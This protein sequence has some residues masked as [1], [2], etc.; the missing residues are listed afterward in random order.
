MS[1]DVSLHPLTDEEYADFVER[2]VDEYA[3]QNVNAGEWSPDDA[4]ARA[5]DALVDLR[6]D[7]LRGT[8]HVF[9]KGVAE[10][11]MRLGWL[12]IAPAPDF[13]GPGRER[14]R[15]LSQ[16]TVEERLRGQGV[17][18]ALL[19][20][21]H[22]RLSAERVDELWLRVFDW[23]T[24]AR[25][26]YGALGYELVRHFATDVPPAQAPWRPGSDPL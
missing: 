6:A 5:R 11:G 21:L 20:A 23:N 22:D 4:L 8:G 18:W 15:W 25:R 9:L 7:R 19:A 17:G 24:A 1:L 14:T 12:W 16:I 2:Q 3:R 10:D 26:L 13:L